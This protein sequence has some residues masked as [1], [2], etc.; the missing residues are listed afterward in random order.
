MQR[1]IIGG[2]M[3]FFSAFLMYGCEYNYQGPKIIE[4][5]GHTEV[6]CRG[7]IT[8]L[9]F[10]GDW[11]F[12]Y[13]IHDRNGL[14]RT[15]YNYGKLKLRELPAMVTAPMPPYP[16]PT[17]TSDGKPIPEGYII[18]S[19]MGYRAKYHNGTWE[20]VMIPNDICKP[21]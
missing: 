15:T 4:I 12:Q 9:R 18:V 10:F 16:L 1:S 7:Q 3:L 21:K 14:M 19:S 11:V 5:N 2:V 17:T 6:A 13:S 8:I 20:P